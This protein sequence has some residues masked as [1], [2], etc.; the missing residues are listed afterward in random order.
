MTTEDSGLPF[1]TR[2]MN[3]GDAVL[4]IEALEPKTADVL[5]GLQAQEEDH[6]KGR[7]RHRVLDAIEEAISE[8][9]VAAIQES[10]DAEPDEV[11]SE[12][13]PQDEEE[14]SE[15]EDEGEGP[16]AEES[17]DEGGEGDPADADEP[18]E[19]EEAGPVP[20][21]PGATVLVTD[22]QGTVHEGVI[23]RA[24]EQDETP[25]VVSVK[26]GTDSQVRLVH[27]PDG[28]EPLSWRTP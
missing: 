3:A 13:A 15:A 25:L 4:S 22:E 16:V 2:E 26:D 23:V 12:G 8:V 14:S 21:E 19:V 11:V 27:D 10:L 24:V 18:E 7:P 1:D 17:V 20:P 5:K 28:L 6:P 9:E